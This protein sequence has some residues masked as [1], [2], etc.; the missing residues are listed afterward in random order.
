M[1][2][3]TTI[4]IDTD[5]APATVDQI[6]ETLSETQYRLSVTGDRVRLYA[7]LGTDTDSVSD[8]VGTMLDEVNSLDGVD[9]DSDDVE[10]G[11]SA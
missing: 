10:V 8:D 4:D 5:D 9:L 6:E 11:G 1:R 3:N 7:R 2:L